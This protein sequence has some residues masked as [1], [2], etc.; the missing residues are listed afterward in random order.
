[1]VAQCPSLSRLT[2]TVEGHLSGGSIS[3]SDDTREEKW[4]SLSQTGNW[5]RHKIDT[6]ADGTFELDD[7]GVFSA[8]NEWQTRDLDSNAT[9]DRYLSHDA[10]GNLTS[11][12]TG[13]SSTALGQ[14]YTYDAFGRMVYTGFGAASGA[15]TYRYNGLGHRIMWQYD[16]NANESF[17][18]EERYYFCYDER[19]RVV[20]TYRDDDDSDDAKERFVHHAAGVRGMG[21]SSYID[22]LVLRDRDNSGAGW[23]DPSDGVLEERVYYIQNW[24]ADVTAIIA[25]DGE[26][27]EHVRYSSY[28]V[29]RSYP[30]GDYDLDG[31]VDAADTTALSNF[32]AGSGGWNLDFNRDGNVDGDDVTDHATY[33]SGYAGG[34]GGPGVQSRAGL[35]NR[36]GYAGYQWDHIV[37]GDHVRHRVY[38]PGYGRW[39]RRDPAGYR[40]GASLVAYAAQS[41]IDA[42]DPFGLDPSPGGLPAPPS[43]PCAGNRCIPELPGGPTL[44]PMSPEGHAPMIP[45]RPLPAPEPTLPRQ[46]PPPPGSI[47]DFIHNMTAGVYGSAEGQYCFP[48]V[49]GLVVCLSITVEVSSGVCWCRGLNGVC[50]R[51]WDSIEICIALTAGV[52]APGPS[53]R[54][55]GIRAGIN[56]CPNNGLSG[57]GG[58][59]CATCGA[60]AG[61]FSAGC[62]V[63]LRPDLS[64]D[65][66]CNAGIGSIVPSASATCGYQFCASE[67]RYAHDTC[68]C[69]VEH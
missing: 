43:F 47:D 64:I 12:G 62:K 15:A 52:G 42:Q 44:P 16:V 21:G 54:L 22:S 39:T 33:V 65:W 37:Q 10:N 7:T 51:N 48:I 57:A 46:H 17:D 23:E 13:A 4:T 36:V 29:P 61:A 41:P 8:A 6:D 67:T 32:I 59:G 45:I 27:L 34:S 18:D 53:L 24:R 66:S 5:L 60:T 9:I 35:L 49:P 19:W 26:L 2:N 28:G 11:L 68:A 63:C 25:S 69:E 50:Q 3:G 20:A 14:G 38:L 30:T 56:D 40:G 55:T 58:G 1:V 31:D